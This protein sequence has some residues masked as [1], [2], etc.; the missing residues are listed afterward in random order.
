MTIRTNVM[1]KKGRLTPTA[2]ALYLNAAI[3]AAILVTIISRDDAPGLIPAAWAQNQAPIAGGAGFFVMPAQFSDNAWG[4][5]LL[6]VDTQTLCAYQWFLGEK[7]LRLVAARNFRYDRR[8]ANFNTD[9]PS[10]AEVQQLVEKE[11]ADDRVLNSNETPV[12]PEEQKPE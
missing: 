2:M 5:Y 4:C 9:H 3:L 10:P 12:S 1:S 11:Q 8:L 7:Q 6:D